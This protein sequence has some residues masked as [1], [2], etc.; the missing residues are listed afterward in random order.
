N[1]RF[2][3]METSDTATMNQW[4]KNRQEVYEGSARHLFRSIVERRVAEEGFQLYRDNTR[5]GDIIRMAGFLTNVGKEI[6]HYDVSG[7]PYDQAIPGEYKI[8]F[9]QRMEVHYL[10]KRDEPR[11][12]RNVTHPVS[13]VEVENDMLIINSQGIVLNPYNMLLLGIMGGERVAQFLPYDFIPLKSKRQVQQPVSP[14]QDTKP[15]NPLS[16]LLEKPY[17]HTDKSYY[18][19]N[20]TVWFRGY[21]NYFAPV[22]KDSLSHVIYVDLIDKSKAVV[23][24]KIFP[25]MNGAIEGSFSVPPTIAGGDY[26]IRAYTRW[27][28]NFDPSLI[29]LKPIK[30]LEYT[31]VGRSAWNGISYDSTNALKIILDKD[32]FKTREAITVKLGVRGI[33]EN[34][35]PANFSISVTD[36]KQAVPAPNETSILSQYKMPEITLPDSLSKDVEFRIQQGI[37]LKGRFVLKKEKPSQGVITVIQENT[38]EVFMITTE[39]DGRF[40]FNN[41]KLYDSAKLSVLAKTLKGKRG[42]ILLDSGSNYSLVTSDIEPLKIDVS[43]ESN[44]SKYN[45]TTFSDARLLDEVVIHEARELPKNSSVATADVLVTGNF[46]RATNANN[47]LLP[48]QSRVPGLRVVNGLLLMGGPMGYGNGNKEDVQPLVLIDG[49]AINS[50]Q[51]FESIVERL[52][53]MSPQE[54]EQIEVYKYSSG[55]AYGARAATGVISITTRKSNDF[56]A[57]NRELA[58][59]DEIRVMGFSEAKRFYSPNYATSGDNAR[60]DYRSTIYWNPYVRT[61]ERDQARVTF[62]A[63]DLPTQYRIV[64]EGVAMDGRTVRAE[65]LITVEE[66]Q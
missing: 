64:V 56:T 37:D 32:T 39:E 12:Y 20:E 40:A 9:P 5:S 33:L 29:F 45:S 28:L 8:Q 15:V 24:S 11:I 26:V 25:I 61:G 44:P 30:V 57:S 14:D 59:F 54:I 55:A 58:K 52:S 17:L 62:Y 22:F 4:I 16:Y 34:F 31:E 36:V 38:S 48:L 3:P 42:K 2:K 50:N 47:I 51:A 41:L 49:I 35:V 66:R 10:Y 18:Y 1:I 43:K 53:S 65:K 60:A 46:L 13:W 7:M 6:T 27:Q 21:M 19:P 63:A 23:L